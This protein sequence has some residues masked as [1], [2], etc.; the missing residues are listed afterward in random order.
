MVV[1]NLMRPFITTNIRQSY[2]IRDIDLAGPTDL[3]QA[4]GAVPVGFRD[5]TLVE[6][7]GTS[8][9]YDMTDGVRR[10]VSPT[11]FSALGYKESNVRPVTATELAV[12]PQGP[13][14]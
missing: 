8:P 4:Q 6:A 2:A 12:N 11:L 9:I 14:L 3:S 5:G 7:S 13:P 10:S 1:S